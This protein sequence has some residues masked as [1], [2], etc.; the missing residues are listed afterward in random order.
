MHEY[1][2]INEAGDIYR[3]RGGGVIEV[4]EI[5]YAIHDKDGEAP[6]LISV[7]RIS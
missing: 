2:L 7:T 3:I 4:A 5:Y 1:V 6:L